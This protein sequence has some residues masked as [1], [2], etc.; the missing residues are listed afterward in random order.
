M[1]MRKLL[2]TFLVGALALT[3]CLPNALAAVVSNPDQ[4]GQTEVFYDDFSGDSLDTDKWLIAEKMWGG[5]NGGVV[6][7]N[8][9]VSDGT[10]KLEGHGN[11]YTGDVEG[12]N[13]NLPGGIRTGAAVATR[14]Y[15]ASGSYEIVAKVAPELGACSAIWTFEY[16][17]YEKGSEGYNQYPDQTGSYCAVN[18]EI[19]I[20]L[21][22]ANEDYD[23]PTFHAAR[24]NTY[25]MENRSNAHFQTLPEAVD[26]G[27]WHTYRFDWHTGDEDEESRVDFYVDGE[28]L[29]T[30]Y[31]HIPTNASRLWIGIWF[32]ASKDSDGD[33]YG[34]TGWTGTADFDTTVFEIDSVKITPYNEAGD[35]VG[36]ETYAKDGWAAD[37]F[38]E[39]IAA[40]NYDHIVNGDFSDGEEGWKLS[41]KAEISDEQGVLDTGSVTNTISQTITVYPNMTYTLKA[42]V[43]TNGT[44]V[45]LGTRK[46]NGSGNT[47]ETYTES[48]EKYLTFTTEKSCTEME[49]YAQVV[50]YQDGDPAYVDNIS[51][52]SGTGLA[53]GS[54]AADSGDESED[55]AEGT[56]GKS[57]TDSGNSGD[58]S[59]EESGADSGENGDL[60]EETTEIHDYIVNG[61]FAATGDGWESSGGTEFAVGS[62]T[63]ISGS[64]TDTMSQKVTVEKGKT[65]TLIVD[66]E[67]CGAELLV[68]VDDYNGRYTNLEKTITS[69]GRVMLTFTTASHIDT[70]KVY[71]KV[72]RY[73]DSKD[74]VIIQRVA[75]VDGDGS[76]LPDGFDA[77][78]E[79]TG[80]VSL[81]T[82]GDFSDGEEGWKLSGSAVIGNEQASLASGSDTDRLTQTVSLEKGRTYTLVLDVESC[83]AELTFGVND[84]NGRYTKLSQSV[85]EAGTYELTFT[86]ASHI[87]TVEVFLQVLRYQDSKE[88]VV[89]NAIE[90]YEAE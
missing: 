22:T 60:E 63:L 65:Y 3:T 80:K 52:Y 14:E 72:L 32:P 42:D 18:H 19:D 41:G 25:E 6:P 8:V 4:A 83:G 30:S 68:G 2:S 11:L 37:S 44:E 58:E 7:A 87:D 69:S 70:V 34:D 38:P 55:D 39:D 51:V 49:I 78:E 66:V 23:T 53:A 17:E 20:E 21:P 28:L 79:G 71:A 48:G 50:R 89:I 81:I 9:S 26:D 57:E 84:Y 46:A 35:T 62:A 54:E 85:T 1:R 24:F 75:L 36:N 73:Q 29:Y 82:N 47:C 16:E 40:E 10:L 59:T 27:E 12:C 76:R 77:E 13:K 90:L 56:S 67:E 43:I 61:D 64:N 33:G 88:P 74:P 86:T 31:E 15:Y 5:W 45:T